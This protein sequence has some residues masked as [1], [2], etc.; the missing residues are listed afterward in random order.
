MVW[1][2]GNDRKRKSRAGVEQDCMN[3]LITF[4]PILADGVSDEPLIV[5]AKVEGYL[6]RRVFVDQGAVVQVMFE[7]CF[8][9]LPPSVK[10]RLTQTHTKLVGFAG[11]QLIP[12]GTIELEVALKNEGLC[13]RAMMKFI[14]EKRTM[15][16]EKAKEKKRER[17]GGPTEEEQTSDMTGVPKRI[18]RHT[19]NVNMSVPP[20]AYK[21]RVLGTEKSLVIMKEVEEWVK[22][23]IVRPVR[24]P[25]WISNQVL[26]KKVDDTWRMCIDFKNINSTCPKDYYPLS[27]IDLKTESVMGFRF[28]CF[29]DTYKGY[30][31]IQ[32]AKE[33]EEKTTFDTDQGTYCYTKMPF[34]LKNVATMILKEQQV[35][36]L[37]LT[38]GC[39][40]RPRQEMVNIWDSS[41]E[42]IDKMFN[43]LHAFIE[44][45][46][47]GDNEIDSHT[48]E[49]SDTLLMGDEVISTT[50]E[51]EN[52]ELIKSS[53][54]DLVPI[55]RESEVT[56]VCD[57]LECD[58]PIN[59]PLPT[60]DVR[61]EYFDINSPLREY[62][63]DF[64][65]ENVDVAGL[66]RYL[67]LVK[68]TSVLTAGDNSKPR[69]YD[70]TFSNLLFDFNDDFTLCN[71]NMLFEEFEDIS[72]L[73]PPELTLVINEST[74]LVTLPL[75]CTDV[76]GD[77]IVDID[78]LL[79]EHLDTLSTGD[80]EID[81]NPSRDIE[82]LER[83]LADDPVPLPRVFDDPLG[84]SDS[85]SRSSETSD[86]FEELIAEIGLD[87]L[88]PIRID[89]R[90]Y[91]S[92]GDTLFF[93]QLLNEDTSPD[94]S[95]SLL[96]TESSSLVTPLLDSKEIS[97]REV[98]RF[99]LF[100]SLT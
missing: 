95:P 98:E 6:V 78:L 74:F 28:K 36:V 96:P 17:Q 14:V 45:S 63:V 83:L 80:R 4:P 49:P 58:M 66:P 30:H 13:R 84:N 71:D 50:P 100:F 47:E 94:V 20:V 52:N 9:N 87:D 81:F 23:G 82:E 68:A 38:G 11:E 91:D 35:R 41:R 42:H 85:M 5:E 93:E 19:L 16:E 32:M 33:G 69:S 97:L 1:I 22:A 40:S 65:M 10:A 34:G 48:K 76:L 18:I 54:D 86:L 44:G 31:Q 37:D 21:R 24:Y 72:S 57:D 75:P 3:V 79:G 51:R 88:I 43:H 60:T 56:S 15:L 62:V 77:A 64:L 27:K 8:D 25:T 99:D 7:Q 55:P 70:A 73:D 90:Y 39:Y 12:I 2:H 46:D 61:E 26:V 92:K 53:V 29:L 59:T 67:V 89:D